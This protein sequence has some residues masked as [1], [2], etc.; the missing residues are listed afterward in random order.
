MVER[1]RQ[2]VTATWRP[3]ATDIAVVSQKAVPSDTDGAALERAGLRY[4]RNAHRW[5]VDS[6][7]RRAALR[8]RS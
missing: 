1:A 2:R 3:S 6:A 7:V 4:E 8:C 5:T